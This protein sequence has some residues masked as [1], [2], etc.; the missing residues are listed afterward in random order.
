[1][2]LRDDYSGPF[3]PDLTL[4]DF[5]RSALVNLAYEYLLI[6]HLLDRCGQPL[7]G[8][9]QGADGFVRSG[10]AEWMGACPIYS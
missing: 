7:V 5:S 4:A 9:E 6:G 1:M 8:M 2:T 3:D 10:I